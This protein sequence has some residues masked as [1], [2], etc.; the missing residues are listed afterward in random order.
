MSSQVERPTLVPLKIQGVQ[1]PHAQDSG[2]NEYFASN[3]RT[4]IQ[5]S[6][7]DLDDLEAGKGPNHKSDEATTPT[8]AQISRFSG[9]TAPHLRR[10]S[11]DPDKPRSNIS[12]VSLFS[13]NRA[14]VLIKRLE[15]WNNMLKTTIQWMEELARLSHQNSRNYSQRASSALQREEATF[16]RTSLMD[17]LYTGAHRLT[18]RMAEEENIF[19]NHIEHNLVPGLRKLRKRSKSL[20]LNIKD[21]PGLV[22]DELSRRIE[23][24][25][26]NTSALRKACLAADA[27]KQLVNNDPWLADRYL[28]QQLVYEIEE[29]NRLNIL[30][31]DVQQKTAL[32]EED[33]L[34]SL[35]VAIGYCYR[36]LAPR[37]YTG[38]GEGDAPFERVL[39]YIMPLTEW[40][41]FSSSHQDDL[42]DEA[43]PL[44]G[45]SPLTYPNQGHPFT[46]PLRTGI[47]EC[48]EGE[49]KQ[50]SEYYYVLTQAGYF[51]QFKHKDDL[52][53]EHS[54]YIPKASINASINAS[55]LS[56]NPGSPTSPR[57]S[58]K[59]QS[60]LDG[61][62]VFE[63]VRPGSTVLKRD[64]SFFYRSKSREDLL[65][66]IWLLS[67]LSGQ[68]VE[69]LEP[70]SPRIPKTP[71]LKNR[72]SSGPLKKSHKSTASLH[73]FKAS[74]P[75]KIPQSPLPLRSLSSPSISANQGITAMF[76]DHPDLENIFNASETQA[77][78]ANINQ[79]SSPVSPETPR[80][81]SDILMK[82]PREIVSTLP[83]EMKTNSQESVPKSPKASTQLHPE[84]SE[85]TSQ[86][87]SKKN[88]TAVDST[89]EYS[90]PKVTSIQVVG[91]GWVPS[92]T[93]PRRHNGWTIYE[94]S[95]GN[96]PLSSEDSEDDDEEN[97]S[98]GVGSS[99][100]AFVK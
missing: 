52:S 99:N 38:N 36:R 82:S 84:L 41:Q 29:E 66:W 53:P 13:Q 40:E 45:V 75:D 26:K 88:L 76:V 57:N 17:S 97:K 83:L 78:S 95:G 72:Q 67:E 16:S 11:M 79:D 56:D 4:A 71:T 51:Y 85:M 64:R 48:R 3:R 69:T 37:L 27:G 70:S 86:K 43:N 68:N 96:G 24:T 61:D 93:I 20:V 7:L 81:V 39:E 92:N 58:Q 42:V 59:K 50:F 63:I 73:Q 23:L 9:V 44:K 62:P 15:N 65:A 14:S 19:G 32:L 100:S 46:V 35:K 34:G 30:M 18:N 77:Y 6:P 87:N 94:G 25:R 28:H 12:R 8:V 22:Q 5:N 55:T 60:T 54:T 31:V 47:L 10:P 98:D 21:N 89:E 90:I 74:V 80:V 33:V 1:N 91:E 49:R 2:P